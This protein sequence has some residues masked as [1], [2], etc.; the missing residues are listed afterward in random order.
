MRLL[1]IQSVSKISSVC[2]SVVGRE[3]IDLWKLILYPAMFFNLFIISRSFLVEFLSS[4]MHR[5]MSSANRHNLTSFTICILL[6]SFFWLLASASV[7][8]IILKR[9]GDSFVP[10][11]SGIVSRFSP[12]RVMLAVGFSY[13]AFTVLRYV[14]YHP[15]F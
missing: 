15:T 3:A 10:A 14:P 11:F 7:Y 4:L 1:L 6:I 13:F 9:S 12:F 5:I 2:L 8:S